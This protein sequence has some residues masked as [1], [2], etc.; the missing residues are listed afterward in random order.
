MSDDPQ[1][2]EDETQSEQ[3][4]AG[5]QAFDDLAQGVDS[6]ANQSEPE[7]PAPEEVG[8]FTDNF[9][10]NYIPDE[11]FD[12]FDTF[13][14]AEFLEDNFYIDPA[15][16]EPID[17]EFSE[18]QDSEFPEAHVESGED[19]EA[20]F[21]SDDEWVDEKPQEEVSSDSSDFNQGEQKPHAGSPLSA[22]FG[23]GNAK[24][25]NYAV[26]GVVGF[27]VI[28][29][30]YLTLFSGGDTQS[31]QTLQLANAQQQQQNQ[32]LQSQEPQTLS[33]ILNSGTLATKQ[34]KQL[35]RNTLDD[36]DA[37]E[38]QIRDVPA[39]KTVS[40]QLANT[41]QVA[42][43]GERQSL[44]GLPSPTPISNEM[45]VPTTN[46]N[47]EPLAPLLSS[48]QAV[49][50]NA[51]PADITAQPQGD[52]MSDFEPYQPKGTNDGFNDALSLPAPFGDAKPKEIEQQNKAEALAELQSI[53]TT[54][55]KMGKAEAEAE[56]VSKPKPRGSN[57]ELVILAETLTENMARFEKQ[58]AAFVERIEAV[59]Q[60]INSEGVSAESSADYQKLA[61]SIEALNKK[62][63][64]LERKVS[65]S[66]VS[67]SKPSVVSNSTKSIT[68]T[69][70]VAQKPAV[71]W[72][73]RAASPNQ[74]WVSRQ[75]NSTLKQVSVGDQ[76][77]GLGTI[78]SIA[79]NNGR[80]IVSASQG[81]ITQ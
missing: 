22:L 60:K 48:Q 28:I 76:L 79:L 65:Q 33:G 24:L 5:S 45:A 62:V 75:G 81:Q 17:A 18:F 3:E 59:E 71:K 36:L 10:E 35:Q 73:L 34:D 44:G 9:S 50:D 66:S 23:G 70:P 49:N 80:W 25:F 13:D 6:E 2:P 55:E 26:Y 51:A 68:R 56:M 53:E 67:H 15:M 61:N 54:A 8:D 19:A 57:Q 21:P 32:M 39:P 4:N 64:G 41:N 78:K 40:Q 42:D 52:R 16:E 38:S 12:E 7:M 11:A 47:A 58:T 46:V 69:Q 43:F 31:Q 63:S 1:K 20:E 29:I 74:A 14:D 72:E 30:G 77:E 27:I 37:L